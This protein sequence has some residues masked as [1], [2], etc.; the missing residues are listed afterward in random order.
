MNAKVLLGCAILGIVILFLFAD[1]YFV[2]TFNKISTI[3][4]AGLTGAYV[5]LTYWI[6]RSTCKA[7]EEQMRPF[8]YAC[9]P[10]EGSEVFLSITNIGACPAHDVKV[11]FDPSLHTIA[12]KLLSK[13]ATDPL[14]SQPFMPP[15]FEVRNHVSTAPELVKVESQDKL[16]HVAISYYDAVGNRF[17]QSYSL[18]VNSYVYTEKVVRYDLNHYLQSIS[19]SLKSIAQRRQERA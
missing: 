16:F 1:S 19:E 5:V 8:V 7:L 17:S 10:L 6:V 14:L 4:L 12:G 13:D 9:L 15:G 11:T 18:N 3:L 2:Q